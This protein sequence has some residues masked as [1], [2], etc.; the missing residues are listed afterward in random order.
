M[1]WSSPRR[2]PDYRGSALITA[3]FLRPV[4]AVE[5]S[6]TPAVMHDRQG[7]GRG[8]KSASLTNLK[9]SAKAYLVH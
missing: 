7:L 8:F 9:S 4:G 2:V 6:D 5:R 3:E 1:A